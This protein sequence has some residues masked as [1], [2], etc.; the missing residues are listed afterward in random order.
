[1]PHGP[2]PPRQIALGDPLHI[3]DSD[4]RQAVHERLEPVQV[5]DERRVPEPEALVCDAFTRI[6]ELRLGLLD[7]FCSSPAAMGSCRTR[8]NSASS[9]TSTSSSVRPERTVAETSYR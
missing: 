4:G 9:A 3:L 1:M 2:V 5:G 6:G 7:A 8:S